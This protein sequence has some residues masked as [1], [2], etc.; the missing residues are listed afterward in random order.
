MFKGLV[1]QVVWQI[2]C[3]VVPR[4]LESGRGRFSERTNLCGARPCA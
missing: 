4:F 3:V 1:S 2:S